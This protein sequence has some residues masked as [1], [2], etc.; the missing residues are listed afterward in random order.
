M[1]VRKILL[2]ISFT[3]LFISSAA[4]ASAGDFDWM[5]DFNIRAQADSDGFRARLGTRFQI[6]DARISAVIGNVPSPGD[7]Y[8][9]FRLGEMSHHPPEEVLGVYKRHKGKGWGVIAKELGIKP[10]SQ[11]FHALKR[12]HDFGDDFGGGK[13]AGKGKDK[14]MDKEHKKNKDRDDGGWKGSNNGSGKG[15]GKN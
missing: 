7:A 5:N 8:M 3:F 1:K 4:I 13:K 12:G 2:L 14:K 10:G 11:E 9:V 6:G 15:H